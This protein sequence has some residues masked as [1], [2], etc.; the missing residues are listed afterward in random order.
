MCRGYARGLNEDSPLVIRV[1]KFASKVTGTNWKIAFNGFS[2][3]AVQVLYMYP[4]NVR[5]SFLDRT[6]VRTY[7]ANFPSVY[8]SDSINRGVPTGIGGS[9]YFSNGNRG[10]SNYHYIPISWPYSSNY[11][12]ISQKVTMKIQ[13]G[14]TCCNAFNSFVLSD[15][16]TGSGYTLL[17]YDN[18]LNMSV[19]RTPSLGNG[20]STDLQITGVVNPYPIQK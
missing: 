7:T 11:N 5:I 1:E 10:A 3:P 4:I 14:I 17:W 16:R 12:D 15:N 8:A 2:N 6:N 19:Y 18:V 13:G 20:W 9:L